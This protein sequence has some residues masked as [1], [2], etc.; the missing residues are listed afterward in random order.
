MDGTMKY[1][2][3]KLKKAIIKQNE[4]VSTSYNINVYYTYSK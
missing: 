4:N 1:K 3:L 2:K